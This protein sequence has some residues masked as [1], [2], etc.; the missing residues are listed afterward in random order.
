[1]KRTANAKVGLPLVAG[2]AA[3]QEVNM[4]AFGT[5]Q[6]GR[7]YRDAPGRFW[8]ETFGGALRA[9]TAVRS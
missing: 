3:S 7:V 5:W 1:M 6:Q 9:M 2:P 4:V 8:L